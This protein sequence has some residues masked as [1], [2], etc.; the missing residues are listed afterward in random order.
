[1]GGVVVVDFVGWE[2][3]V[4]DLGLDGLFVNDRL[5]DFVD[6]MM[7]VLANNLWGGRGRMRRLVSGRAIH[8]SSF[9]LGQTRFV[10]LS[11]AMDEF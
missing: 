11:V 2:S 10:L 7:D 8:E 6:V 9:H 5:D 1:M 3:G 4:D